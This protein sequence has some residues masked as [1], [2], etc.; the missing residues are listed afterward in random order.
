[1]TLLI[2]DSINSRNDIASLIAY[3]SDVLANGEI[4]YFLS[5]EVVNL[6]SSPPVEMITDQQLHDL[7]DPFDEDYF[8]PKPDHSLECSCVYDAAHTDPR[9]RVLLDA[10]RASGP[11]PFV[12]CSDRGLHARLAE[13]WMCFTD[14][15]RGAIAESDVLLPIER[16]SR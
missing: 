13:C 1:M 12:A 10:D 8:C 11:V 16:S 9:Q 5:C 6:T 7:V 15:E 2:A 4:D 3:L 14:V